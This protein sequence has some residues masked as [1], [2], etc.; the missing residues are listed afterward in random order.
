MGG[1]GGGGGGRRGENQ[2]QERRGVMSVCHEDE[3][4]GAA[5]FTTRS[6]QSP[7]IPMRQATNSDWRG[8]VWELLTEFSSSKWYR[9][10]SKFR[11]YVVNKADYQ[12]A[13]SHNLK[14][15]KQDFNPRQSWYRI[16]PLC[17]F[18]DTCEELTV[19]PHQDEC[20]TIYPRLGRPARTSSNAIETRDVEQLE[21]CMRIDVRTDNKKVRDVQYREFV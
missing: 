10:S 19:N 6:S 4:P 5:S 21:D 11:K 17:T 1:L 13:S 9:L 15:S 14:L 12:P 7:Y 8:P 18:S 16:I 2:N 3:L 20:M